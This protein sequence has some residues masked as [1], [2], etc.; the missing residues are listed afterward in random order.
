MN[1][2]SSASIY[3]IIYSFLS[4]SADLVMNSI[5]FFLVLW[6][7]ELSSPAIRLLF[8]FDELSEVGI[9]NTLSSGFGHDAKVMLLLQKS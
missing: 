5:N 6:E 8:F 9:R 1:S 7:V 3:F 2:G 4:V